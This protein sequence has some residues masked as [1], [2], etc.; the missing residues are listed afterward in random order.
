MTSEVILRF[1]K[2]LRLHNVSIHRNFYQ[3]RSIN[4]FARKKKAKIPESRSPVIPESRSFLVRYR[5]TYVLNKIKTVLC[6]F[7]TNRVKHIDGGLYTTT[8]PFF[9]L[10]INF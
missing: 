7:N 5:R 8:R 3:N 1:M 4:E 10:I 2:N 9:G 6:P